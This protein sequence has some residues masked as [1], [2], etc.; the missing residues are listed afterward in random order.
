MEENIKQ[1]NIRNVAII[2][3]VDHGKTTL[4][5]ALM[6]QTHLFRENQEEMT[7]E[8]ILDTGDLEK[9][10]GITINA[11]NISI[12]YRD[13]KINIIDTPGHADFGGEVE[14]TLNMADS[15]LLL[16]D[17][18]EGVMPQTKFVLKKALS[19]GLKVIVVI[20]KIDKKLADCDKTLNK[21]QDLFLELATDPSQLEFPVLYGI[22][23]EGKIFTEIPKGDLTKT[24]ITTGDIF[25]VLDEIVDNMPAPEG[26]LEGPFQ[27]QI[28]SLEY[29][30]HLGRYLIGKIRRGKIKI[31]DPI[32]VLS[33]DKEGEIKRT[34]GR[35]RGLFTKNGLSWESIETAS[36]GDIV[37][38]AGVESLN[39]GATVCSLEKEEILPEIDITPPS[40]R[41][42]FQSNTSPLA[43]KEG[44][45]VTAKQLAQRLEQEKNLN[46]GLDIY[47]ESENCHYVSG[48]GELQ[49]SILVEQLRRE[50]YEF[51]LSKPEIILQEID[52]V[53]SEPLEELIIVAADEYLSVITQEVSERKGSLI[54]IESNNGNST[55]TYEILTRNLIGLHRVITNATKGTAL[56]NSYI[57]EYVPYTKQEELFRKGVIISM[58]T[59]TSLDY[60][61]T[62]IQ[63]RG[64]LFIKG[65]TEVY[66]GMIIGINNHEGDIEVNP[67]KAR[68][69]T[70]VRMSHAEVTEI[71][72]K[73]TLPLSIEF[74]LSFIN[75]DELIEVTPKSIRLRK[76]L[77]TQTQRTWSK[78]KNLTAYAK[79]HLES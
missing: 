75:N 40:V 15:C 71:N 77:L 6:K 8:R 7:Q 45:Y 51:Q 76:K 30:S 66:E 64:K 59:G 56:I 61:L 41:V 50:G 70:N 34:Q 74:A 47:S 37:A 24:N 63:E 57:K 32:V 36:V 12:Y 23:R 22:S 18:Q 65:S 27:M 19:L 46:V 62:S 73:A 1:E 38:I 35:V 68:K 79:D 20:N 48:R 21:I 17:A 26:D 25:P 10:K 33:E 9:E 52:G 11:K 3:H 13:T 78:R 58:E 67:C 2:A 31:D 69:K 44:E 53:V 14:R 16:V 5:D 29:D 43:G 49:L 28:T 72:L 60:A 39:I 4:V 42:K 55:F 54:N